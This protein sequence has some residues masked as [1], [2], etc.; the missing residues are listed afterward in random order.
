MARVLLVEN[1]EL[2]RSL[3]CDAIQEEGYAAD[4]VATRN[5]AERMLVCGHHD[6]VLCNI[7]LPDGSG[8]DI[9]ATARRRGIPV[10]LMSGRSDEIVALT[11]ARVTHLPKPF[12]LDKFRE[13][14]LDHLGP[15]TDASH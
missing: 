9:A 15:V 11:I 6:L 10:V 7:S 1:Q 8:D 3:L 14:L 12:P 2:V 13:L 5:E 4:C